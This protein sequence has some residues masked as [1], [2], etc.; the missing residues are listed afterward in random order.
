LMRLVFF[1]FPSLRL[2]PEP[3]S[4]DLSSFG[5]LTKDSFSLSL[6]TIPVGDLFSNAMS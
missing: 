2:W 4:L 5:S 1:F 6:I 3:E